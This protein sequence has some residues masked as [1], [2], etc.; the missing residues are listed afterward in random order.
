MWRAHTMRTWRTAKPRTATV[1]HH[2]MPDTSCTH[3]KPCMAVEIRPL[4]SMVDVAAAVSTA[5]EAAEEALLVSGEVDSAATGAAADHCCSAPGGAAAR[6]STEDA[7][8]RRNDGTARSDRRCINI[9]PLHTLS[10]AMA[11]TDT[12]THRDTHRHTETDRHTETQ[13]QTDRQTQI[14]TQRETHV[15]YRCANTTVS[16]IG[17]EVHALCHNAATSLSSLPQKALNVTLPNTTYSTAHTHIHT[18]PGR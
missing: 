16:Y 14:E 7:A 13:R 18:H 3:V 15:T 5:A 17:Y 4:P 8:T 12:Q 10:L 9:L 2:G 1:A 11:H 6:G